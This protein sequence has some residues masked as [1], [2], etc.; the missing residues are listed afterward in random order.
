MPSAATTL[1]DYYQILGVSP[2]ADREAIRKAYRTG[3][4][5]YH[6]D[7][8]PAN[9]YAAAQF[10][11]L[12]EAYE[13]LADPH[14]RKRYDEAR[15]LRG[16]SSRQTQAIDGAGLAADSGKLMRHLARIGPSSVAP[17][18]LQDLLLYLL[19][20]K[21]LAILTAEA[22]SS[23]N[24]L[25]AENIFQSAAYL[26]PRLAQTIYDRLLLLSP[27]SEALQEKL[28]RTR[29]EKKRRQQADRLTPWIIVLVTALLCILMALSHKS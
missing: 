20:D 9:P 21:H 13:V 22:N 18:A 11:S 24:D 29:A 5:K 19:Q 7:A 4:R 6:P 8:A 17:Y 15:W 12:Q 28:A 1:P 2:G 16:M 26:P 10:R 23:G 14:S 27:L 3:V 25:F